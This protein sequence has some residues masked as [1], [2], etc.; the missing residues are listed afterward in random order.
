MLTSS[1]AWTSAPDLINSSATSRLFISAAQC[2]GVF[3]SYCTW[4]RFNDIN[5]IT[6][7]NYYG[8]QYINDF[9]DQPIT[10]KSLN[11][12]H[13]RLSRL[14]KTGMD[15]TLT[16]VLALTSAPDLT[17]S[18]AISLLFFPAASSNG[19]LRNC[20]SYYSR[21]FKVIALYHVMQ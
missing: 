12:L 20:N 3:S 17:N 19:V 14:L 5:H 15:T 4:I 21:Y 10:M 13:A 7:N 9:P 2:S 18:S 6:P 11:T 16:L 1:L 8:I